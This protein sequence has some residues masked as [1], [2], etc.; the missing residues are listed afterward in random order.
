MRRYTANSNYASALIA[1]FAACSVFAATASAQ[2]APASQS[3]ASEFSG[4]TPSYPYNQPTPSSPSVTPYAPATTV[5]EGVGRSIAHI[6]DAYANQM[7]SYAQAR[8][9]I[10][11]AIARE[12]KLRVINSQT[13]LER[14]NLLEEA[15][16][17]ERLR[18]W[19]WEAQ[20]QARREFRQ[21]T[22]IV[23]A[24]RL[25][26]TQLDPFTGKIKWPE[27]LQAPE[28]EELTA[29]LDALFAQLADEGAQYDGLYREP[30]VDCCDALRDRL[31]RDRE[32]KNMDW[33]DY[34]ACQKLI[35][36]LKYSAKYWPAADA[37]QKGAPQQNGSQ[38]LVASLE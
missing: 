14:K 13:F 28:F 8:L 19:E 1:G 22:V 18:K 17:A 24:Y 15:R 20:A 7:L 23:E 33:K 31:G 16:V 32:D 25:P 6:M 26:A 2:D 30:I 9:L 10:D 35:V 37:P 29:D 4:H 11:E 12:M 36:G 5:F 34:I 3:L 21:K 38:Q 27:A